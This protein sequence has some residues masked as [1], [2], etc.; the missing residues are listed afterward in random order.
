M[1]ED[2]ISPSQLM[3]LVCGGVLAPAAEQLPGLLLPR[4]GRGAWLCVLLSCPLVLLAGWFLGQAGKGGGLAKGL[5]LSLGR[6]PGRGLILLYMLWAQLLLTLRLRLCAQR[7]LASGNRDGAV[8]FFLLS[9]A[10]LLLWMGRGKLAA[11]ARAGQIYFGILLAAAGT[12]LI[13]SAPQARVERLLPVWW[14]EGGVSISPVLSS[15]GVL[16]W[17]MFGAFLLGS[18]QQ[19]EEKVWTARRWC[20]WGVAGGLLLAASQAMIIGNLGAGLA[21]ELEMPFF[22]LAK[23]VGVEGA[24]QRVEGIVSALW[25]LADLTMG[26]V[27][28]FAVRAMGEE[29][30][31]AKASPWVPWACVLLAVAGGLVTLPGTGKAEYIREEWIPTGNLVL[32]LIVPALVLL[33]GW[34]R[35]KVR[36]NGISGINEGE[37]AQDIGR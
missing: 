37:K 33:L 36:G 5:V 22:S 9:V 10:G 31:P 17:G 28:V 6:Y 8:W 1:R 35:K 21:E 30:L 3:M 13:L 15:A 26:G 12:V 27:L 14:G 32:G 23:S 34:Y 25:T 20:M 18:V 19:K 2:K 7:L 16:G 4:A 29:V 24:F 11:F